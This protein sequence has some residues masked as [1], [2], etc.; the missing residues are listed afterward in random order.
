M[1]IIK[2][3]IIEIMVAAGV[4]LILLYSSD[5][6]IYPDSQRFSG[7]NLHDPPLYPAMIYVMQLIFGSLN[8]VIILQ[9]L[10][11]GSGIIYFTRTVAIHFNLDT[12]IKSFVALFLFLPILQFYNIL[13]SE[14]T[15]YAFSLLFVSFVIK[16]IYSLSIQNIV[17]S[18]IFVIALL[19]TRNQF[20]FLYP[21]ILLLYLGI[22][23][24]YSSKKTFTWLL[25]SF[26]SIFII[27]IASINLNK[28]IKKNNYSKDKSI[29]Y[30]FTTVA[31]ADDIEVAD[32]FKNLSNDG[33]VFFFTFI[34]AMYISTDKD[35][36]LFENENFQNTFTSI[37]NKLDN[38]K[39]LVKYYDNRGHYS[40]SLKKIRNHSDI[41][42]KDLALKENTT[43]INIKKKISIKIISANFGKY[44]KHIF[45]KFYDSTWLFVFVPFFMMMASLIRFIEY[46]SKYSLL[47]I[48]LSVFAL[49]N[50]TV[51]YLFGR[52]QPRYFIYTDFIIL[53]F[54]FITF[55]IFLKRE[56]KY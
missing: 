31:G 28:Y 53:V 21:V 32:R 8:S 34:D 40:L 13:I 9:T 12:I 38:K 20:L 25:V 52:V 3:N 18:T 5:A 41:F 14:P 16:S 29:A 4:L 49:A 37:L 11:V 51:I 42:L 26:L 56:K 46:K 10:F 30:S 50:H 47:L 33:G 39:A 35:I 17:W 6:V 45:K 36:E 15:G 43:V 22:L 24:L 27:H 23:I 48:F 54:I 55:S 19:L 1:T 44:T 2:N 7:E